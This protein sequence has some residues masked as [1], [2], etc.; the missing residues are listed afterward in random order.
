MFNLF[1]Q[2][3]IINGLL[4]NLL[5]SE[6]DN[7]PH[8]RPWSW[9]LYCEFLSHSSSIVDSCEIRPMFPINHMTS[10]CHFSPFCPLACIY[11]FFFFF[12]GF[13]FPENNKHT[14]SESHICVLI[15]EKVSSHTGFT[16]QTETCSS[17]EATKV[18]PDLR[19]CLFAV[20]WH[21]AV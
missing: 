15:W 16:G 6:Y 19:P 14:R 11:S 2:Q 9:Y 3:I 10:R 5:K 1:N 4:K 7:S 18:P 21:V 12:F 13:F 8:M 17:R 20:F